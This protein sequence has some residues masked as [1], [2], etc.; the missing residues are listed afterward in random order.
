M[1]SNFINGLEFQKKVLPLQTA[2]YQ[3]VRVSGTYIGK[4]NFLS[5]TRVNEVDLKSQELRVFVV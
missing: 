3:R 4:I 2:D 5:M 1:T